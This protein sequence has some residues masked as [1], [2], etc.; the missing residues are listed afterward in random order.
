MFTGTF[1][2]FSTSTCQYRRCP[3]EG[4]ADLLHY[5]CLENSVDRRAWQATVHR[6][7]KHLD[8]T[9]HALIHQSSNFQGLE[10]VV[11]FVQMFKITFISL[12]IR[13]GNGNPFQYSCLENS[14]GQ[15][16]PEGYSP[17]GRKEFHSVQFSSVAQ[18]CLTLCDP[19]F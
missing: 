12:R 8:M 3:G 19:M 6:I 17:W 4:N 10:G 18:S 14:Q 16:I 7:A 1:K 15:R 5:S 13:K 9:E 2:G 11:L